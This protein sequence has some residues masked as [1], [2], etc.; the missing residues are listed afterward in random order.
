MAAAGLR[1]GLVGG[2]RRFSYPFARRWSFLLL[3]LANIPVAYLALSAP[4]VGPGL[5][6]VVDV[7]CVNILLG[8]LGIQLVRLAR[9]MD[10]TVTDAAVCGATFFGRRVCLGWAEV[11]HVVRVTQPLRGGA[12]LVVSR[13]GGGRICF[14]ETIGGAGELLEIIKERTHDCELRL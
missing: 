13:S 5:G 12:I 1:A 8:P 7:L 6:W 9:E 11:G 10:V 14:A 4:L 3:A 2:E